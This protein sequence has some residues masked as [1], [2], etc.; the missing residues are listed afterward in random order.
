MTSPADYGWTRVGLT[1]VPPDGPPDEDEP[2]APEDLQ[3]WSKTE[4]R[5]QPEV[6]TSDGRMRPTCPWCGQRMQVASKVCTDC[7]AGRKM[8]AGGVIGTNL[9]H[10]RWSTHEDRLWETLTRTLGAPYVD[11]T[12][13]KGPCCIDCGCLLKRFD[14]LCPSC[15]IPWLRH[16][17]AA[18]NLTTYQHQPTTTETSERIAA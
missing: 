3:D 1:W 17:A 8:L 16:S 11:P 13:V 15:V 10:Y 5:R 2:D 14:E 9:E 4:P 6:E 12:P 18:A 7:H